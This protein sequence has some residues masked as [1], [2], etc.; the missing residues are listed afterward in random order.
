MFGA[1][2]HI[3][4]LYPPPPP[5][6]RL[7]PPSINRKRFLWTLSPMIDAR[8]AERNGL[9]GGG[10]GAKRAEDIDKGQTV[11]FSVSC[12]T[13]KETKKKYGK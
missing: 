6:P 5:L 1:S 12:H 4:S 10:G 11:F 3:V 7:R 13:K 9:G 2:E 8:A